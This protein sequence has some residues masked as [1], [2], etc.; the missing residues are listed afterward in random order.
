MFFGNIFGIVAGLFTIGFIASRFSTNILV[1]LFFSIGFLA[2]SAIS[3]CKILKSN[4]KVIWKILGTG[5]FLLTDCY[6][7]WG[8]FKVLRRIFLYY[9]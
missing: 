3:V 2:V 4:A 6:V 5:I 8:V 1:W 7:I 9:L